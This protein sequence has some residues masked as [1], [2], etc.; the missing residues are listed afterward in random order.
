MLCSLIILLIWWS[1]GPVFFYI[2]FFVGK[3]PDKIFRT[4][5]IYREKINSYR[6]HLS[7]LF[8][9]KYILKST[10]TSHQQV[11]Y[12]LWFSSTIEKCVLDTVKIWFGP[13]KRRKAWKDSK[14]L[15]NCSKQLDYKILAFGETWDPFIWQ[16]L[17][18]IR[19]YENSKTQTFVFI[20]QGSAI[21]K[22]EIALGK[23][24]YLVS[25]TWC[26]LNPEFRC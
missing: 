6:F 23:F 5:F 12:K 25:L 21:W 8:W 20:W 18:F 3:K 15:Q 4:Y 17:H 22:H 19:E 11:V 16:L 2:Y 9:F 7:T 13:F 1:G 24:L 10:S 26:T 14:S